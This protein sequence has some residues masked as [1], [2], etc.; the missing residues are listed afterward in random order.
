MAPL[1]ARRHTEQSIGPEACRDT[2]M[3]RAL[4]W[5][6]RCACSPK[7]PGKPR[8]RPI[9]AN[10]GSLPSRAGRGAPGLERLAPGSPICIL[11]DSRRGHRFQWIVV[12]LGVDQFEVVWCDHTGWWPWYAIRLAGPGTRERR[13]DQLGGYRSYRSYGSH[14]SY[15]SPLLQPLFGFSHILPILGIAGFE[16]SDL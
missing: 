9:L 12:R 5:G 13:W 15:T 8:D 4:V 1:Y 14:R 3:F 7:L 2:W 16:L 10:G 6:V 11:P